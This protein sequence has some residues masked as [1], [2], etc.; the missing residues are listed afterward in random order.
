MKRRKQ[1]QQKQTGL[2]I[3]EQK[4]QE[5]RTAGS[6][7]AAAAV[8]YVWYGLL[9][10]AFSGA[11]T[12][13]FLAGGLLQTVICTVFLTAAER[14]GKRRHPAALFLT[15]AAV[16]MILFL[17]I[18][19]NRG[20]GGSF[21]VLANSLLEYTGKRTG[22]YPG[23]FPAGEET[24]QAAA[25]FA[26]AV[27]SAV[28]WYAGWERKP[29]LTGCLLTA[30]ALLFFLGCASRPV[31]AVLALGLGTAI[32]A[33][34]QGLRGMEGES[35]RLLLPYG[36][37][38]AVCLTG[39][40]LLGGSGTAGF[41][42]G[43]VQAVK[44]GAE[45]L[46]Y[47]NSVLPD[48][49]IRDEG[50][51]SRSDD[52]ALEVVM[53][54][55]ESLYL[56]GFVGSRYEDGVWKDLGNEAYYDSYGLFYWLEEAGF[57]SVS[58]LSLLRDLLDGTDDMGGESAGE[59]AGTGDDVI[60]VR[61]QIRNASRKYRYLPYEYTGGQEEGS[62]G[63]A[64]LAGE[65]TGA[66]GPTGISSYGF[67]SKANLVK[68]YPG[69]AAEYLA[70]QENNPD[71]SYAEAERY[72]NEFV[73]EHYRTLAEE[74]RQVLEEILGAYS[75]EGT[76]HLDYGEAKVK[77][78]SWLNEN[79]EYKESTG[80]VPEGE[81]ALSYILTESGSGYDIHYATAAALMYRYLGIPAR[82]V[83]GYLITLETAGNAADY[84]PVS[85]PESDAHAWVEIYQDGVGW[86]PVETVGA[87]MDRMEQPPDITLYRSGDGGQGTSEAETES[88]QDEEE[89]D[90]ER[91][92]SSEKGFSVLTAVWIAGGAVLAL[93]LLIFGTVCL[94]KR[95]KKIRERNRIFSGSDRNR[96]V[97]ALFCWSAGILQEAGLFD[98]TGSLYK[99][100]NRLR[101]AFGEAFAG[102]YRRTVQLVQSAVFSR[103]TISEEDRGQ[104]R[105]FARNV[106]EC[107]GAGQKRLKRI[108]F[109]WRNPK[110][111]D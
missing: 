91:K 7:L 61:V 54:R 19:W 97:R 84:E 78:L 74:D 85:V 104:V 94:L 20:L 40:V 11:Q 28:F 32:L 24:G 64:M 101:A 15:A 8:S 98:G 44:N 80:A 59:D 65:R 111:P 16:L 107:A 42:S 100:E 13:A 53:S 77:I 110:I 31:W 67:T 48:G 38:L 6:C 96:A 23:Q 73:Y 3:A 86:V 37:V 71:T 79:L 109:R 95:R 52:T 57:D 35:G 75:F 105:Q 45:R 12:G 4:R 87:Y 14:N 66:A 9:A 68:D 92:E 70:Y 47:G 43:T 41:L 102:E 72:Y 5:I 58:Q 27:I 1:E 99:N 39:A 26:G 50:A 25:V 29:A 10:A 108:G 90:P 30:G 103:E 51:Y 55:P 36:A 106:R 56:R 88:W 82:Y 81:Q 63:S 93:A 49:N 76:D 46:R 62:A 33:W 17:L 21:R 60:S 22:I 34:R 89:K 2:L 83:E 18:G 69:L